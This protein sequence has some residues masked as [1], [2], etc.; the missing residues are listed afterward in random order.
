MKQIILCVFLFLSITGYCQET[1]ITEMSNGDTMVINYSVATGELGSI[2]EGVVLRKESDQVH[3]THVLY[4]YGVSR[5]PSGVT[6]VTTDSPIP[7]NE[8]SITAFYH[9]IKNDFISLKQE[10]VLNDKQIDYL[11]RF[12]VEAEKF[13][14]QGFSNA[15][16][17]YSII[18]K[19][20]VLVVLDQSGKWDKH[21]ELKNILEL[22]KF[23]Q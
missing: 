23:S 5:L 9:S 2:H 6:A 8:D 17:Y 19:D 15:P 18:T 11:N 4:N 10:W 1:L 22:K 3:A 20:R 12:L 16:E 21:K 14:S 13:E 7:M